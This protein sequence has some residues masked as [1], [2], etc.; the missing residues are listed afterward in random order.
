MVIDALEKSA[1]M[2][3]PGSNICV[4]GHKVQVKERTLKR[5]TTLLK[6]SR[7]LPNLEVKPI[8]PA[9]PVPEVNE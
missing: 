9:E 1:P 5:S 4:H 7:F 6:H 2:Q 3:Q 8:W